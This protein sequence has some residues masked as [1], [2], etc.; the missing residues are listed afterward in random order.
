MENQ[1]TAIFN[2]HTREGD[3]NVWDTSC[4]WRGIF[5]I[6]NLV[7]QNRNFTD[8]IVIFYTNGT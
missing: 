5:K 2:K 7:M 8:P 4:E 6:K 3:I 1:L